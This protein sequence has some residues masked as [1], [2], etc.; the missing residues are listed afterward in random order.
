MHI[1]LSLLVHLSPINPILYLRCMVMVG[2]VLM[3]PLHANFILR[4]TVS[5]IESKVL[6]PTVKKKATLIQLVVPLLEAV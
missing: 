4:R 2:G 3:S 1:T 6:Y 5:H